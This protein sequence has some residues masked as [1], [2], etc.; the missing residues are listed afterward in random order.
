MH[1]YTL[2]SSSLQSFNEF[3]KVVSVE[4]CWQTVLSGTFHF[5][6]ISKFKK[7]VTPRK[8][9]RI[10]ISCG[11]AH[12]HGMPLSTTKF[13]EIL[14]IGFRGGSCADKKNRTDGLTDRLTDW[15]TDWLTDGRTDWSKTC[16]SQLV[17]WGTINIDFKLL[18]SNHAGTHFWI[19]WSFS[20]NA[21]LLSLSI[22][23]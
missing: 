14:L 11:Y 19:G 23:F 4:L 18:T 7:G 5:G 12:L 22:Q 13:H 8:K 3:C 15:L 6:Q 1:I 9:N 16:P 10:I 17:A 20:E 21:H 2:C